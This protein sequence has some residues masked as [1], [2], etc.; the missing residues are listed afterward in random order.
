MSIGVGIRTGDLKTWMLQLST[1][2]SKQSREHLVPIVQQK[3][4]MLIAQ[5]SFTYLLQSPLR[6]WVVGDIEVK[7]TSRSDLKSD[8]C[9]K[10][11]EMYVTETKK[12]QATISCAWL[13]MKVTSADPFGHHGAVVVPCIF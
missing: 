4:V 5:K 3:L 9:I 13:R 7:Q 10:D 6:R 1:V 8:E 2:S 12:S 11:A